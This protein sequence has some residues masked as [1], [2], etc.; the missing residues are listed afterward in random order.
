MKKILSCIVLVIILCTLSTMLFSCAQKGEQAE[1]IQ[2]YL[3]F[4]SGEKLLSKETPLDYSPINEIEGTEIVINPQKKYQD[5]Y[6]CGGA[7]THSSAFLLMQES[8]EVRG[9]ILQA[10]FGKDGARL[11][12]IRLPIGASDYIP[13]SS[14]FTCCD[15]QNPDIADESLSNFTL[16]KDGEIIA[17]LKEILTINP[18]IKILALP[19]SAPAW[20]KKSKSLLGGY[21]EEKY[22]GVFADYLI[23]FVEEYAK[24]GINISYLSL[25]NE[26][27][28]SGIQYPHMYMDGLQASRITKTLGEKLEEKNLSVKIL[29]WDHNVNKASTFLSGLFSDTDAYDYLS[30][31]AFHGYEG[32]Y[33]TACALYSD[34]HSDK[35]LFLTEIT[36]HS[37]STNFGNNFAYALKH[38]TLAPINNGSSASLFWNLVLTTDG[39]P[40]PVDHGTYCFGII[41][42]DEANPQSFQKSSAYYAMAHLSKFAYSIEGK[43][44]E[45]LRALCEN[46]NLLVCALLRGDG[47]IVIAI[48]NQGQGKEVVKIN[49]G[50]RAFAYDMP[51]QSVATFLLPN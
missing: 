9:E 6:G 22:E 23:K 41:G 37:G 33:N 51:A 17:L 36:E 18:D 21:L 28:V 12:L 4:C 3:S 38:V 35:E 19:W 5:Y 11:S 50:E 10:L 1:K 13:Q 43:S 34:S 42:L 30:G 49:L 32:D 48:T 20:M 47:K 26:P 14:F 40:T 15:T 31:I 39:Q 27:Y 7:L 8:A 16:E 2:V 25:V 46:P 44:P 24:E 29:G 45:A